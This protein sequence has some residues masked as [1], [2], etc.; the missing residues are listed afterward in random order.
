L[1]AATEPPDAEVV[2]SFYAAFSHGSDD[3]LAALLDPNVRWHVPGS[4]ALSGTY[5]GR[6]AT[7]ALFSGRGAG[8]AFDV[9]DVLTGEHFVM[10]L[11]KHRSTRGEADAVSRFV[12]VLRTKSGRVS[13]S[14]HFD[15]DQGRLDKF[16]DESDSRP[17]GGPASA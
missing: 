8:S 14:W 3:D 13:E 12:H 5:S 10:V 11:V 17:G 6:D 7:L 15:E 9:V 4:N 2:R 1:D 16:V